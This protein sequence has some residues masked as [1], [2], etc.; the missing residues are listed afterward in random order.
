[1]PLREVRRP[2]PGGDGGRAGGRRGHPRRR[3]GL[4]RVDLRRPGRARRRRHPADRRA[5]HRLD[6][7]RRAHRRL[8]QA[9]GRRDRRRPAR[10]AH[11]ERE[12][13]AR[14]AAGARAQRL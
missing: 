13:Q 4:L 14:A 1:Q 2:R 6:G 9:G 7:R 11:V 8:P 10:R 5:G 3:P 12:G